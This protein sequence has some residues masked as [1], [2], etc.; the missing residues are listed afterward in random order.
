MKVTTIGI[1]LAKTALSV[2]DNGKVVLRKSMSRSK[3]LEF[4]ADSRA[5]A[6]LRFPRAACRNDQARKGTIL[7]LCSDM[8]KA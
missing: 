1:D 5:Q 4:I 8:L 2:D 7:I 3:L 6:H